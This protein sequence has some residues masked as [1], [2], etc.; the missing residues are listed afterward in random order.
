MKTIS[1]SVT[2]EEA[3]IIDAQARGKG[4]TRSY[5]AKTAL[6]SYVS[7]YPVRGVWEELHVMGQKYV[8]GSHTPTFLG[9]DVTLNGGTDG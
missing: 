3:R 9:S 6:F 5:L 1:F 7:K 8:T 4:L 2:D